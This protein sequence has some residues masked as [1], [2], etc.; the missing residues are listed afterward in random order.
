MPAETHRCALATDVI[1]AR[2]ETARRGVRP[3]IDSASGHPDMATGHQH[4]SRL[5]VNSLPPF[6]AETKEFPNV[7]RVR[8]ADGALGPINTPICERCRHIGLPQPLQNA[9]IPNRS[10]PS[11]PASAARSHRRILAIRGR[12]ARRSAPTPLD[13]P[14]CQP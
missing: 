4:R 6:V 1:N 9:N 3:S 10:V 7:Q 2:A 8:A 5:A 13:Q 11:M 14:L 12:E